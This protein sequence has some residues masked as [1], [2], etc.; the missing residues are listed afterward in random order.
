VT[1]K[2]KPKKLP[3]KCKIC[4]GPALYSYFGAVV[5]DSCR[6]FFRRN[7]RTK[8][9][10]F[11]CL[12]GDHCEININNRHICTSCRLAKCFASGMQVE[13]IRASR[14]AKNNTNKKKH[15]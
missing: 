5:C 6:I 4:E 7:A 1:V 13:M 15:Q 12:S 8:Q 9:N 14:T 3:N 10:C 11:K 2:Q